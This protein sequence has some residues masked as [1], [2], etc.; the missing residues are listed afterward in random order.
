MASRESSDDYYK[1]LGVSKTADD[2]ELKKAYRKLALK[3]HPDK[4]P[5][6]EAEAKFKEISEAYD[7]LSDKE[8]RSAY[9]RFGKAGVD[10]GFAA[11]APEGGGGGFPGGA[12]GFPGGG[13]V[14]F[15]TGGG[16]PMDSRR[17]EEIFAQFFGGED[18]FAS[19]GGG[20]FGG[21][22]GTTRVQMGGM[23][24]GMM[25]GGMQ[26]GGMPGGFGGMQGMQ[27][28]EAMQGMPGGFGGMGGG[29][30]GVKRP[31][32]AP[33][34]LD[35]MKPGTLVTI[36]SVKSNPSLNG[37]TGTIIDFDSNKDRYVINLEDSPNGQEP[38]SLKPSNLQQIVKGVIL[39]NI[40]SDETLNH[41][42]GILLKYNEEKDR[43][44]IHLSSMKRAVSVKP[45]NVILPNEIVVTL[46]QIQSKP[47]VNGKRGTIKGYDRSSGRYKV[48][49]SKDEI[50]SVK[51]T[52]VIA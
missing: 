40:E 30:G 20:G 7:C 32:P 38:L 14:H 31:A 9:D 47:H 29:R 16:T 3:Y 34:R 35:A 8:K 25:F 44:A 4:N 26:Q 12:G 13:N 17:A 36:H 50:M 37:E 42:S 6:P 24:P 43:Y 5:A 52:N 11:G 2:K 27:G 33:T 28:F 45:E 49:I 39:Q 22:G 1:I 46:R 10:G 18:P 15:S 41:K 21:G 48:Q 51:G 19:M 23:P